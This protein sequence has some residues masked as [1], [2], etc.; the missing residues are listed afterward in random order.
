VAVSL[1]TVIV[2]FFFAASNSTANGHFIECPSLPG[3]P[4]SFA[5]TRPSL[6]RTWYC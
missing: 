5:S 6:S 2:A 1:P 4:V 3:G